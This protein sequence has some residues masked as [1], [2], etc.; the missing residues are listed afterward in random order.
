MTIQA[1]KHSLIN[2]ILLDVSDWRRNALVTHLQHLF[3]MVIIFAEAQLGFFTSIFHH[4][5]ALGDMSPSYL[6]I[7]AAP[8]RYPAYGRDYGPV[9]PYHCEL[10]CP[11]ALIPVVLCLATLSSDTA[12]YL[13]LAS[14]RWT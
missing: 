7:L 4:G 3:Q 13:G 5:A 9:Y 11:L 12:S 10:S 2:A 6:P 14:D 8:I 1:P